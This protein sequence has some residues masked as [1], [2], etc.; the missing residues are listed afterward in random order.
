MSVFK[1]SGVYNLD[2]FG[3]VGYKNNVKTAKQI[4]DHMVFCCFFMQASDFVINYLNK[5]KC[6]VALSTFCDTFCTL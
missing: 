6:F 5:N 4:W 3:R 2:C 1:R